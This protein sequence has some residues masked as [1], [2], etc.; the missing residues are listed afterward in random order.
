MSLRHFLSSTGNFAAAKLRLALQDYYYLAHRQHP[1]PFPTLPHDRWDALVLT[2]H[3]KDVAQGNF[4]GR[5]QWIFEERKLYEKM[6]FGNAPEVLSE[7][8]KLQDQKKLPE[9]YGVNYYAP[10]LPR[11]GGTPEE[12]KQY[13]VEYY[14]AL[15]QFIKENVYSYFGY[16]F[17]WELFRRPES[18][19]NSR[20]IATVISGIIYRFSRG[21]KTSCTSTNT[22]RE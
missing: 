4:S 17:Y 19:V 16:G 7:Q 2:E 15:I 6:F 1:L 12:K 9:M 3:D 20:K 10:F 13:N 5:H 11:Y 22:D 21:K 8:R 18:E 14:T